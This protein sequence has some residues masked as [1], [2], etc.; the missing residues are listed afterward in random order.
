MFFSLSI[1]SQEFSGPSYIPFD[2]SR[3]LQQFLFF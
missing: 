1:F 3:K 2:H